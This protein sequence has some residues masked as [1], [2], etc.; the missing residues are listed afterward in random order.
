MM[1]LSS[2]GCFG[3]L[4]LLVVFGTVKVVDGGVEVG[5]SCGKGGGGGVSGGSNSS[6]GN[7]VVEC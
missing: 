3:L 6:C 5:C 7:F 1:S 2:R 4:L